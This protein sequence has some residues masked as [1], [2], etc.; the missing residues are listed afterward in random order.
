MNARTV[1]LWTAEEQ[2]FFSEYGTD[3]DLGK[4]RGFADRAS[5]RSSNSGPCPR[6][7]WDPSNGATAPIR[8]SGP[9]DARVVGSST[10][11]GDASAEHKRAFLVGYPSAWSY[12]VIPNFNSLPVEIFFARSKSLDGW[13]FWEMRQRAHHR[14]HRRQRATILPRGKPRVGQALSGDVPS[15]R[16]HAGH[17]GA[18][19][20]RTRVLTPARRA[21]SEVRDRLA[22]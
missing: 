17:G 12:C 11:W 16:R 13:T 9:P 22:K 18:G 19:R 8:G 21:A 2:K 5:R 20:R 14:G 15:D 6:R 10:P 3:T 4:R 1:M 7:S